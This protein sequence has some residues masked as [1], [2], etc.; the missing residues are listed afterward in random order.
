MLTITPHL[1]HGGLAAASRRTLLQALGAGALAASPLARL[2]EETDARKKRRKGRRKKQRKKADSPTPNL[3]S[4]A[5]CPGPATT[6]F[7]LG[8]QVRSAQSFA[9]GLSGDLVRAEL[10]IDHFAIEAGE[11]FLRL[12]PLLDG[13]PTEASLATSRVDDRAL[14]AGESVVVFT[15]NQ[16][17][18][19]TAG[20]SYALVLARSGGGAYTWRG[21]LGGCPGRAFIA[22]GLTAPFE[23]SDT[24][25]FLFTAFVRE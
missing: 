13:L 19:V 9:S 2:V 5:T 6:S 8:P 16:P 10:V 18:R 24:T 15:F 1:S 25:D 21:V 3:R 12:A 14:P 17:A 23:P 11:Y 4:A 7:D 20:V 22:N